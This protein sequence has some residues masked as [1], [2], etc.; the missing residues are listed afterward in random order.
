MHLPQNG[1]IGFGP[2]PYIV[3]DNIHPGTGPIL[4]FGHCRCPSRKVLRQQKRVSFQVKASQAESNVRTLPWESVP[5]FKQC[6]GSFV[7]HHCLPFRRIGGL[8]PGGL[9]VQE[10]QAGGL[11]EGF[12][13][14]ALYQS[15]GP[16]QIR[17]QTKGKSPPFGFLRKKP[18]QK[19]YPQTMAGPNHSSEWW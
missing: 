9:V 11:P 14:F 16:V 8:E 7:F 2:R 5:P 6:L 1:T 3:R 19:G 10:G 15:Q 12:T 17:I 13:P 18:P 4:K